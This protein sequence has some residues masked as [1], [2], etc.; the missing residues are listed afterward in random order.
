MS[1]SGT[2][3]FSSCHQAGKANWRTLALTAAIIVAALVAWNLII[4]SAP[5]P[6][7]GQA[8]EVI[9]LVDTRP[10]M[11]EDTRPTL[12][13]GGLVQAS[14]SVALQAEVSGRIAWLAEHAEPGSRLKAGEL[15]ARIED[16]DFQLAVQQ[17][18]ATLA[19]ARAEL[20][21]E[22]GQIALAQ[23]EY[24]LAGLELGE[25]DR[26]L[27]LREPQRQAAEATVATAEAAL[28][29][30]QANL[31]RTQLTMPFDGQILER[32]ISVGSQASSASSLFSVVGTQ[33][34]YIQ[35]KVPRAFLAYLDPSQPAQIS[36]SETA[37]AAQTRTARVMSILPQVESS[38]RQVRVMLAVDEP[39]N[40]DKG[41]VLLANDYVQVRLAGHQI[42]DAW[43]IPRR[44]L[45]ADGRVWVVNN[46]ELALRDVEVTYQGRDQAWIGAGF[47]PGDQ[48]LL[49]QVDSAVNGMKVRVSGAEK[50]SGDA[51]A[52]EES[53]P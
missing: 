53:Q 21:I 34:F 6:K 28:R 13:V 36:L 17:A 22:E 19:Q 10:L 50:P 46:G 9:R 33:T 43:V 29:Q 32:S 7:R 38:D 37:S 16:T 44:V 8:K 41:P 47:S 26:A 39:L 31:Q 24:E 51:T 3:L 30:A 40:P 35:A 27:V 52:D 14:Q 15:L 42:H 12:R 23:E 25:A 4:H 49:S 5:V 11:R 18:E 1:R 2:Q 45:T 20:A 48:L